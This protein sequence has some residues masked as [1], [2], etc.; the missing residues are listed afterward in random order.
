MNIALYKNLSDD[1]ELNKNLIYI[2]DISGYFKN[3]SN[4]TYTNINTQRTNPNSIISPILFIESDT[5]PEF[6]FLH[7]KDFNRYYFVDEIKCIRTGLWEINCSIDVLT[8]YKDD[9]L[10]LNA[11]VSKQELTNYSNYFYDD[12]SYYSEVRTFNEIIE[13]EKGFN[14]EFNYIFIVAGGRGKDVEEDEDGGVIL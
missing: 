11:I 6:N 4:V 10:N 12:D 2:K 1:I 5:L 14:D 3:D 9:I 8:T 7:I 13:F